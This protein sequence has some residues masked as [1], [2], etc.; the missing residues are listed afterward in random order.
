MKYYIVTHSWRPCVAQATS[1]HGNAASVDSV[2]ERYRGKH[3]YDDSVNFHPRSENSSGDSLS[4][5]LRR[6]VE[7]YPWGFGISVKIRVLTFVYTI[8]SA[9]NDS[10][11]SDRHKFDLALIPS[12][13][14]KPTDS[15]SEGLSAVIR[16]DFTV[17]LL[18]SVACSF[19]RWQHTRADTTVHHAARINRTGAQ[20]RRRTY[21]LWRRICD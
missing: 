11:A 3:R 16:S 13:V 15:R 8:S 2:N 5:G 12:S 19:A 4:L 9:R 6:T 1:L 7:I 18:R 10:S 20:L 14:T 17:G 21:T